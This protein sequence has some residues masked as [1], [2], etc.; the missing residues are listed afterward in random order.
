[1]RFDRLVVAS[2]NPDKI[3]EMRAVL[4]DLGIAVVEGLDWPEVEETEDSL[5]GNALLK[6]RTVAAYTGMVAVADDTGLEVDALDGAP[7][8][9]SGRF[10]GPGATYSDNVARLL[11]ELGDRPDREARFRTVIALVDPAGDE[12]TA[13]GAIAGRIVHQPRGAY[14]FGYDPVFEVEGRTLGE[15]TTAEKGAISHRA[16]ALRAMA[17]T[18]ANSV[19][20]RGLNRPGFVGDS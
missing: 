5:E 2:K 14:G 15:M 7:G 18:L 4:A 16:L 20:A 12:W 10:A 3:A 6:A 13:E 17:D 1:M 8:V 19:R 11:R 9:R